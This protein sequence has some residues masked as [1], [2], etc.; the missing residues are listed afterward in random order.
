MTCLRTGCHVWIEPYREFAY[1]DAFALER[2]LESAPK[3]TWVKAKHAGIMEHIRP[4]Y[5][6]RLVARDFAPI[7]GRTDVDF[8]VHEFGHWFGK[9]GQPYGRASGLTTLF[10]N[11]VTKTTVSCESLTNV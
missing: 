1:G 10:S 2:I 9:D 4:V 11:H 5:L 8:I 6:F 7:N 3:D